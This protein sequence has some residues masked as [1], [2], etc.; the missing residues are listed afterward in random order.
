MKLK[1]TL[2]LGV[3]AVIVGVTALCVFLPAPRVTVTFIGYTNGVT[4]LPQHWY[5]LPDTG[6]TSIAVFRITNH[7]KHRYW[8]YA[9]RSEVRLPT[10]WTFDTNT[11]Y[12][13]E[14]TYVRTPT[15][16]AYSTHTLR[17]PAPGGT[18]PWRYRVAVGEHPPSQFGWRWR[19]SE[20]LER[21]G[22]RR[23]SGIVTSAE[24]Q[25]L[26]TT[27]NPKRSLERSA[28]RTSSTSRP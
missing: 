8:Y 14:E 25:S 10:G 23:Y 3:S 9:G 20:A 13:V 15:L 1:R 27:P 6:V 11:N 16:D 18:Y 5:R 2:I 12:L 24:I 19:V 4:P 26:T 7:T 22:I 28:P 21:I 17:V